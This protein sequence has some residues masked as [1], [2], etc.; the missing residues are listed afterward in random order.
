MKANEFPWLSVCAVNL[1]CLIMFLVGYRFSSSGHEEA[2]NRLREAHADSLKDEINKQAKLWEV[3]C[4]DKGFG[5]WD[6]GIRAEPYF[7]FL[8]KE[9]VAKSWIEDNAKKK[10]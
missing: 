10:K 6:V 7:I 5:K 1:L 8:T 2:M 9:E 3:A 4:I